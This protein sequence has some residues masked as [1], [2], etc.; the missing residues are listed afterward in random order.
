MPS[1]RIE[2]LNEA[3]REVVS[4]AVLFEV[5]D[6]RV[7]GVTVLDAEVAADLRHAT[8]FV[9]VMGSEAQQKLALQRPPLGRRLPPVPARRP[10][11]DPVHPD[12]DAS[13]S[14][15]GSRSRSPSPG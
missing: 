13:S 15:R 6:P 3:I 7:K 9:S 5:A 8:V 4:S 14:T 2:R 12:P 11:A 10:A 1:H